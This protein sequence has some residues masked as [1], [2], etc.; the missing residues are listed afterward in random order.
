MQSQGPTS[1]PP[2]D[3]EDQYG[4]TWGARRAFFGLLLILG[5]LLLLGLPVQPVVDKYG[6]DSKEEQLTL[7]VSELA[8]RL[9]LVVIVFGLAGGREETWWRL[10]LRWP[11]YMSWQRLGAYAGL[12]LISAWVLLGIYQAVV[13]LTGVKDLEPSS[14]VDPLVFEDTLLIVM[15][16]INVVVA[17]PITEEL[18]FRGFLFAGLRRA[19]GLWPGL[20][21]S[22]VLFGVAHLQTDVE[23]ATDKQILEYG[24]IIPTML[25]AVVL[26]LAY[27]RSRS[28]WAPYAIHLAFNTISFLGLLLV[29][30]A[31]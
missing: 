20:V 12:G 31:R 23:A 26:A 11:S 14:Q 28:L 25:I 8:W 9:I 22:S 1:A 29:P 24:L 5:T 18:F 27:Q 2:G 21:V 13:G 6:V 10:G 17:A 16:G 19:W 7:L 3:A 4:V 30:E 15:I